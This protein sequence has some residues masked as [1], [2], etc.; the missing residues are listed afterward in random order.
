MANSNAITIEIIHTKLDNY[1]ASR[2]IEVLLYFQTH[3]GVF[4]N[5]KS[6]Y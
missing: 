1:Q 2:K 6:K 4:L 5:I 3:F